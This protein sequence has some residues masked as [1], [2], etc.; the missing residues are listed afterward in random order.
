ME[1]AYFDTNILSELASRPAL[2]Q[3]L[4]E[5]LDRSGLTVAFTDGLLGELSDAHR[6]HE[7]LV[8][9]LARLPC[10]FLQPGDALF[11][12]EIASYDMDRSPDPFLSDLSPEDCRTTL[13]SALGS[14]KV[15]DARKTMKRAAAETATVLNQRIA[16]FPPSTT[17]R[18]TIDQAPTF[19][20]YVLI[21]KL[22]REA[23]GFLARFHMVTNPPRLGHFRS[24][25][26][27]PLVC[28]L[29]YYLGRRKP[30]AKSDLGDLFHLQYVPYCRQFVTER[31]L[32]DV[33]S[34]AAG[35]TE[36][37]A[38]VTVQTIDFV[39]GL[40]KSDAAGE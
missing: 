25:R 11:A 13:A 31:D 6:K 4:R 24:Q 15:A 14:P 36:L 27:G 1:F 33:L 39:R 22:A 5:H 8:E 40:E 34:Q 18:Y 28:F 23:P 20:D 12:A 29:K 30:N 3:A 9:L 2:W 37:L 38:G 19:V 21:E 7:S 17:G 10:A 16:N 32:V 35:S 26:L